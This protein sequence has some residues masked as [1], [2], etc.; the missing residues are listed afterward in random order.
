[1]TDAL[2]PSPTADL[3]LRHDA[4]AHA[5][6]ALD[7]GRV[8]GEAHY[9]PRDHDG[10]TQRIFDHTL[11]QPSHRGRGVADRLVSHAIAETVAAGIEPQATCWYVQG[12]LREHPEALRG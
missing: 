7:G 2:Q 12:W 10:R 1:M 6:Q 5:F 9:T 11:T 3:E 4:S 8:V